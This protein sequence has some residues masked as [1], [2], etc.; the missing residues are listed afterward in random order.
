[1]GRWGE[2]TEEMVEDIGK[3]WKEQRKRM[4]MGRGRIGE[5]KVRRGIE[6]EEDCMGRGEEEYGRRG[7]I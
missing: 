1:V 7:R 5:G 6:E 3:D 4:R 2:G